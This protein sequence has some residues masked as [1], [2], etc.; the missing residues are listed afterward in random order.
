[1]QAYWVTYLAPSPESPAARQEKASGQYHH[2]TLQQ[3][4]NPRELVLELQKR[5]C[6]VLTITPAKSQSPLF[7][8]LISRQYK[9]DFLKA[10]EYNMTAGLSASRA[11]EAVAQ[12]EDGA[13]RLR[14]EA[15][16]QVLARG[17]SFAE[18]MAATNIYDET[19]H[20]LLAAG[21]RTG[22]IKQSL[23]AAI[24]HYT[25]HADNM[26]G[27]MALGSLVLVDLVMAIPSVYSVRY[28][29]LPMVEKAGVPQGTPEQLAEFAS[30]LQLAYLINDVL[31]WSALIAGLLGLGLVSCLFDKST[32]D[33]AFGLFQR[34][35]VLG[36]GMRDSALAASQKALGSLLSGGVVLVP[37]IE[38]TRAGVTHPPVASYW[39][40]VLDRLIGGDTVSRAL[41]S[42]L[43]DR[44]ELLLLDS[45][46]NQKQLAGIMLDIAKR[47][48][49]AAG[50]AYKRFG[51]LTIYT[52]IGYTLAS[53]LSAIYVYTIQ[54]S[55]MSAAL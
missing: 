52:S 51:K 21:E 30:G 55:A 50:A 28:Q 48:A 22:D 33:W 10:I 3:A 29:M 54:A 19:T 47:R 42:E 53:A 15:G 18:A 25:S 34:I 40:T 45:H 16:L 9:I 26:K 36:A 12:A 23:Q 6:T 31:L 43:L 17:G 14:L 24:D 41:R 4:A 20:I 44:A 39:R 1:M 2:R 11:F 7:D 49:E 5:G 27:L 13:I 46:Q 37:A 35:P 32:R 38:I 8:K